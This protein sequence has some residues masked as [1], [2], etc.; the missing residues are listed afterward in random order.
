MA[1][2][3]EVELDNGVTTKYHRVVSINS[4]LNVSSVIEV[5]SYTSKDKRQE[6]ID[7][8]KYA[9][10]A[11]AKALKE[12]ADAMES[13]EQVPSAVETMPPINVFINTSIIDLPYQ[14]GIS[15]ENVYNVLKST[16]SCFLFGAEDA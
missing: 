3:K 12:A 11:L 5:A 2:Y 13:G 16:E 8:M 1:L 10:D 6:E 9:K 7:Q 4:V 14:P 15:P